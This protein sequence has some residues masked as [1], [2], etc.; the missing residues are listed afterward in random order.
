MNDRQK[1]YLTTLIKI[2]WGVFL[3]SLAGGRFLGK[4]FTPLVI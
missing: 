3:T 2:I 1:E 4:E